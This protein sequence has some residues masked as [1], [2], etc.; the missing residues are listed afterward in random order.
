MRGMGCGSVSEAYVSPKSSPY[1]A[2]NIWSIESAKAVLD[3]SAKAGRDVILQ[4]S[5]KAFLRLDKEE[6]R[7]FV[8][9]YMHKKQ[10]RAY[11]HLDHCKD[12]DQIKE[13]IS[14]GWDSVMIDASHKP[15]EENIAMTNLVCRMAEGT[16]ILVEAEIGQ[17]FKAGDDIHNAE[18]GIA[19]IEDIKTFVKNTRAHILA[20]AVGTSHGLYKGL[21]KIHYDLIEEI[22]AFTNIPLAIH[23]G[24][25][26]TDEMFLKLLSHENVKKINI[27]TD[28]KMAFRQGIM[29]SLQKGSM[30]EGGFDPM[31]VEE[32]IHDF[33]EEM[34]V[35]KLR[36]LRKDGNHEDNSC[37][38]YGYEKYP[39]H[40][41]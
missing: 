38:E 30:S 4:T 22:A 28:V 11:L 1:F 25:G 21:P 37:S 14:H 3:G 19:R 5:M 24:T 10:I 8:T 16:G 32:A 26:L 33:L 13:A 9:S 20:A 41:L 27:S 29:E 36:L 34:A 12:P 17:I 6:L 2:F 18:T 23:G 15:L 40:Y 31:K 39:E 35:N 7:R